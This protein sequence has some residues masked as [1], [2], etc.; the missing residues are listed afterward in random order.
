MHCKSLSYFKNANVAVDC[1][2][3]FVAV[4]I[5]LVMQIFHICSGD[6]THLYLVKKVN[7]VAHTL[8]I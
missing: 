8:T 7:K 6:R 4:V 3:L 5:S 2:L 1:T